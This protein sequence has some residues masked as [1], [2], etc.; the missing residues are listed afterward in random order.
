MV[1]SFT[2]VKQFLAVGLSRVPASMDRLDSL[3]TLDY[4][5]VSGSILDIGGGDS[6]DNLDAFEED[7]FALSYWMPAN[8]PTYAMKRENLWVSKGLSLH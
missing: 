1:F 3:E 4:S 2:E 6:D 8:S 5:G 7:Y